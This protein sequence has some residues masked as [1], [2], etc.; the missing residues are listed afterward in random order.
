MELKDLLKKYRT[1]KKYSQRDMGELL[2]THYQI[3]QT[4]ENGT[5]IPDAKNIL[6]LHKILEIPITDLM[7]A[8]DIN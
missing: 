7:E 6:K 8:L 2:D 3:Y 5:Y 1:E 4:W